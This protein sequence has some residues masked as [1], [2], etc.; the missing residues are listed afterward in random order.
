MP[1]ILRAP[2]TLLAAASLASIAAAAPDCGAG[3]F[4]LDLGNT[5]CEGLPLAKSVNSSAECLAACCAAGDD[6]ETWQWCEAGQA[7]ATGYWAQSGTLGRGSDLDG[8]PQNTTVATAEAACTASPA[9]IGYTYDSPSLHPG[10]ATLK[11]YLKNISTGPIHDSTW[12]RHMKASA[13]CAIGKLDSSCSNSSA[14]WSSRA[15]LPRPAGPCDIFA[16]AG[17][18]CVAAHSVV[19]TLY[20]NYSG[21][22]YRV[23]RDSDHA[24]LDIG[25]HENGLAKTADQ[26]A[27][28]KDTS[29]YILRLFDQSPHGNHLDTSPAGG[30]CH[31]P[32]SP[33]NATRDPITIGGQPGYGAFFEGKMGYRRDDTDGVAVGDGEQTIYMVTRGDHVNA[34]CCF[35]YG[36]AETDN[37][38]DGQGTMSALYFGNSSAWGHGEGKGPWVMADLENGLWAGATKASSAPSV[39]SQYVT[40]MTKGKKGGFALKGGNAQTGSLA[41]LYEGARP[42]GY[43]V[44]KQQGAIILGTGGDNSCSAI[45]TFYE[46]AMTASYTTDATDAAL[47]ANVVAAGYGS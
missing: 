25:A 45:G 41:K 16:A 1:L 2:P 17:T 29:C 28:C 22:L 19:R 6:C 31:I 36:N 4:P 33:V 39:T 20:K 34:G 47:Q 3:S 12:S 32:L 13:G 38:D 30:A 21:P 23:L 8:W 14:G 35:D 46:G 24:G 43:E 27:F 9:C 26:D 40:A 37:D 42:P 11:I 44:M 5:H 18:P 7:C 10:A 15:V